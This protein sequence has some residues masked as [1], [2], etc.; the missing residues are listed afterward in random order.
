MPSADAAVRL[1]EQ[2]EAWGLANACER[3]AA[4]RMFET[5]FEFA[6]QMQ[7]A[8]SIHIHLKVDDTNA[9][10]REAILAAGGEVDHEKEGYVKFRFA[11]GVNLIFSSIAVSQDE[12]VESDCSRRARPFVDH[13]GIDL[14]A[15]TPSV[16]SSFAG[17]PKRAEAAGWETVS[18]GGPERGVHCC[19]VEVK[20]KHWVY[21]RYEGL[22]IPLEFAFGE[23]K[24]NAVSG[25]CDLRPMDPEVA[26]RNGGTPA[27]CG[28]KTDE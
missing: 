21:P 24:V 25:G 18:Q 4:A 12:L 5:Q 28:A 23:L 26:A 8:E 7:Q 19:H 16:S 10:P 13:F 15:E 9:L 27:A 11:G 2:V 6:E 14:R 20:E 1:M 3:A 17:I 22:R